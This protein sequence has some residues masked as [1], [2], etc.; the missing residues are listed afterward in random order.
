MNFFHE[1][2]RGGIVDETGR[3]AAAFM[4][5]HSFSF[6]EFERICWSTSK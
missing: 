6:N 4:V 1:D 3:E 2:G 5:E